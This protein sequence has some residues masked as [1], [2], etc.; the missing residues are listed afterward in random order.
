M[1]RV[2]Y[3]TPFKK[4]TVIIKYAEILIL[5]VTMD[6]EETTHVEGSY[7]ILQDHINKLTENQTNIISKFEVLTK[8]VDEL[9]KILA[10]F[11]YKIVAL[12]EVALDRRTLKTE[13]KVLKNRIDELYAIVKEGKEDDSCPSDDVQDIESCHSGF[14][15]SSKVLSVVLCGKVDRNVKVCKAFS[16]S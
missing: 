16:N 10:Q 7:T 15:C 5:A 3:D 12:E 2:K 4:P 9:K 1:S 11:S 14:S 6:G 13:I 8:N